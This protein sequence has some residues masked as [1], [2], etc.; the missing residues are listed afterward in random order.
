MMGFCE[1][2]NEPITATINFVVLSYGTSSFRTWLPTFRWNVLPP[3]S[4]KKS[5]IKTKG[6]GSLN[7]G[8]HLLSYQKTE[9]AIQLAQDKSQWLL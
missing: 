4:E 5:H 7:V 6:A 8:D 1:R 9:I 3:S 2:G